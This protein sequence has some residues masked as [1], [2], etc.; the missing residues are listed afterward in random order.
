MENSNSSYTD[1]TFD[2]EKKIIYSV[3]SQ[4]DFQVIK[5]TKV[6]SVYKVETTE[7][8]LC[9]KRMRHGKSKPNNCTII[10]KELID[11]DFCNIAKYYK[12]KDGKS[13]VRRKKLLFYVTDWIEGEEGDL[14]NF[15]E[16]ILIVKSL[17]QFHLAINNMDIGK[18]KLKSNLKN[19]HKVF[20]ESLR[21]LE[22]YE[23]II[24]NKRIKSEFD[25]SYYDYIQSMYHRGMV[26]L[27]LLNTADYYKLYKHANKNKTLCQDNFYN[28]NIV[29][30]DGR[31]Y[32]MDL[33]NIVIDL[34]LIDLF[35]L[36]SKLIYRKIIEWDFNKVKLLIEAYTSINKLNKNELEVMLALLV[37]PYKF[38][39]LGKKRYVKHKAWDES[40]YMHKLI[41]LTKYDDLQNKFL[42][43]FLCYMN[44]FH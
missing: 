22:K 3:L 1:V 41:K 30:K 6:R 31:Y 27:N 29:K 19:W 23:R 25:L 35:N 33:G 36:I 24:N 28:E 8:S 2:K 16:V 4:Y 32:I 21:G 39:K 26:A 9:L 11:T 17:A 37:F 20:T 10:A 44:E 13:Y 14:N 43:D 40:K 18:L 15:K 5:C 12:T 34:Q 38:W 42:E 7:C